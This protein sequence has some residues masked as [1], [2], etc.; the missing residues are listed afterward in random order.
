MVYLAFQGVALKPTNCSSSSL[1]STATNSDYSSFDLTTPGSSTSSLPLTPTPKPT[2]TSSSYPESKDPHP[3][4][5]KLETVEP[6]TFGTP[7]TSTIIHNTIP[8]EVKVP[9]PPN[10]F[11]IYRK[12][13]SAGYSKITAAE[14][15]KIL[16]EQ[17]AKEPP[18]RKAY[19]AKLA[20]AAEKEH[21]LKF[22]YYKFTPAKRGT[23]RR[24]KTKRAA[25]SE[26]LNTTPD[27]PKPLA[28][29]PSPLS[30]LAP[31]PFAPSISPQS[32]SSYLAMSMSSM[33]SSLGHGVSHSKAF[34][35]TTTT[36]KNNTQASVHMA[37][38]G[39]AEDYRLHLNKSSR[40]GAQRP[41]PRHAAAPLRPRPSTPTTQGSSYCHAAPGPLDLD[42]F[43]SF[44]FGLPH[45]L[46]QSHGLS[47]SSSL[48]PPGFSS[49]SL[50][51][52]PVV[53][54]SWQ[55]TPPTLSTPNR[56]TM[57]AMTPPSLHSQSQSSPMPLSQEMT[58][59]V[60]LPAFDYFT[61]QDPGRPSTIALN[62]PHMS[63][64]ITGTPLSIPGD[65]TTTANGDDRAPT[66]YQWGVGAPVH[67]SAWPSP[68]AIYGADLPTPVSPE[69]R[70]SMNIPIPST[71]QHHH[72]LHNH[73]NQI[74]PLNGAAADFAASMMAEQ[75]MSISPVLSS[76]SSSYSSLYSPNKHQTQL[77]QPFMSGDLAL[78]HMASKT[79]TTT[80]R[81][82]AT[83]NSGVIL[84]N[85]EQKNTNVATAAAT[86]VPQVSSPC[87]I[88]YKSVV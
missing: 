6:L 52:D 43:P 71:K 38:P 88:S 53:P 77:P 16:G 62:W 55:W 86:A 21:A 39:D 51:F 1:S 25:A 81:S 65:V 61:L 22:P 50:L 66:S 37:R 40:L 84:L 10:S 80:A 26:A 48:S 70:A 20:K 64:P 74:M 72:H 9:R 5:I 2:H 45:L 82:A 73:H 24:A 13:H 54:T 18:E 15:S 49:S 35:Y 76:C 56:L 42:I 34:S 46:P 23:G 17:W 67:A 29:K 41:K 75:D 12:E 27:S 57:P 4:S 32:T 78:D 69:F 11:I 8:K 59:M 83:G 7:L 31:A 33:H 3:P 14:L 19:Y 30:A 79:L 36:A 28:Y 58:Q 47:G 87:P 63:P 68:E 44:N 85:L 60:N